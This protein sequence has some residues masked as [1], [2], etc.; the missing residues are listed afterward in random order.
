[1]RIIRYEESVYY[2]N[3]DNFK[4]KVLKLS[5]INPEQIKESIQRE[6]NDEMKTFVRIMKQEAKK[7]K[8]DDDN[9]SAAPVRV[10]I[11]SKFENFI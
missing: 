1:M 11:L 10:I 5:K 9:E 8:K 7:A 2:A 3:V 6:V 4:Y